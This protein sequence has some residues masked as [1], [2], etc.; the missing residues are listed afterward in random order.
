MS[1]RQ[2]EWRSESIWMSFFQWFFNDLQIDEK[3]RHLILVVLEH[4]NHY[5]IEN[6]KDFEN[7]ESK[8]FKSLSFDKFSKTNITRECSIW[9]H[10]RHLKEMVVPGHTA[11]YC[12][13]RQLRPDGPR[14]IGLTPSLSHYGSLW[15]RDYCIF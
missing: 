15:P 6:L 4:T 12:S 10:S 13:T 2:P 9:K 14:R 8:T 11:T 7:F 3:S 1:P 5:R